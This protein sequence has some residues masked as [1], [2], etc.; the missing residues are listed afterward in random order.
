M[1]FW[2]YEEID[3]DT[4]RSYYASYTS[5]DRTGYVALSTNSIQECEERTNRKLN[6]EVKLAKVV[7]DE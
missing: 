3:S 4:G 1:K 2:I 7:G 5:E 6:P